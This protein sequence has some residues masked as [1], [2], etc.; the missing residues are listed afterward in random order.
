MKEAIS[1]QK[2]VNSPKS[3]IK[4]HKIFNYVKKENIFIL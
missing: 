2:C 1:Q 4:F 3:I